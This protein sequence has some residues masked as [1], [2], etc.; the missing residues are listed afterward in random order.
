MWK[1]TS[2]RAE[3]SNFSGENKIHIHHIVHMTGVETAALVDSVQS[4][5]Y[6]TDSRQHGFFLA[7]RCKSLSSTSEGIYKD[8]ADRSISQEDLDIKIASAWE[9]GSLSDYE[10]GFFQGNAEVDRFVAFADPSTYAEYPGWMLRNLLVLI[11][12]R[13][14]LNKVNILCYRDTQTQR[15]SAN[16]IIF[17]IESESQ[18]SHGSLSSQPLDMPRVTGWERNGAGKVVSRVANLSEFMDPER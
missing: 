3:A 2:G 8:N 10:T 9:I 6:K 13:W 16:S 11:R 1:F 15:D 4:W 17:S 7:K 18:I 12:V 14:Q 5:R